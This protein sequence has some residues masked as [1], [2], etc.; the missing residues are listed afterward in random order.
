LLTY[1]ADVTVNGHPETK[2]RAKPPAHARKPEPPVFSGSVGLVRWA[3]AAEASPSWHSAGSAV[4]TAAPPVGTAEHAQHQ[5]EAP[6]PPLP[7]LRGSAGEGGM[8]AV[9]GARQ[10]FDRLGPE[11]FAGWMRE[12]ERVLVTDTTMR[13][14]HQSL[15]ATRIRTYDIAAIAES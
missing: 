11:R 3:K 10:I 9:P 5:V 2:G 6:G 12:Q 7:T 15:L 14:A 13:D 1:I 4:P 8:P